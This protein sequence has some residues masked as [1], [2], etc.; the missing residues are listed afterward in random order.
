MPSYPKGRI[1]PGYDGLVRREERNAV[2]VIHCA[3]YPT[4]KLGILPRLLNYFSFI[5]SS[6]MLGSLL[7]E[8]P[9]VLIVESPP[10]FLG[11]AGFWLALV[12]RS[13]VIMN[14]SDLWPESAAALGVITRDSVQF[15]MSQWLEGLFYRRSWLVAGQTR[16]ILSDIVARFPKV[17]TYLLSNGVDTSA[18]GAA[19]RSPEL[20]AQMGQ[21]NEC[22]A[23]YVGLHGLAQGLDQVIEAA[24][25]LLP[26]GGCRF[27]L[28]G[29]G[30]CKKELQVKAAALNLSNVT[31]LASQPAASMPAY[32]AS[33]DILLVPL[34]QF[35]MGAVPSKLYEA[36]ASSQPVV[37]VAEGEAADIAR[38]YEAG[39]VVKPG[40]I[41]GLCQAILTL[42]D[43]P[44]TRRSLGANGRRAAEDHFDSVR[45]ANAFIS[46]IE[47]HI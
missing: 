18:Y 38:K 25:R 12:K 10:I 13:R 2:H 29:D 27:V 16:S 34:T 8:K 35:I 7:L 24:A 43:N 23:L 5:L 42:R 44:M 19:F 1:Y 36:M 40:D 45:I 20:R 3:I 37:L 46:F 6:S 28:I 15:R 11:L 32:V 39:M 9:D 4:Q 22:V 30:P 31:F 41:D 14:I 26:M 47:E 33:A 17:P 21:E